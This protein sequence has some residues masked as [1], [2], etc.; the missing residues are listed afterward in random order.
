MLPVFNKRYIF[1][2]HNHKYHIFAV[3][4]FFLMKYDKIQY[5]RMY[6]RSLKNV[7]EAKIVIDNDLTMS[8]KKI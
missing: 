1:K 8:D 7:K 2:T 3:F 6:K 5:Y 4:Q